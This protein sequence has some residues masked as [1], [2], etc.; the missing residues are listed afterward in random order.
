MSPQLSED[1]DI[2]A[3]VAKEDAKPSETGKKAVSFDLPDSVANQYVSCC[4]CSY[5]VSLDEVV[6]L[7]KH[8]KNDHSGKMFICPCCPGS[9]CYFYTL[10]VA[11]KHIEKKHGDQEEMC[12]KK[13]EEQVRR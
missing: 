1:D 4:S 8:Y 10:G 7:C 13:L 3:D 2:A 6:D 5:K 11:R 12:G 9:G